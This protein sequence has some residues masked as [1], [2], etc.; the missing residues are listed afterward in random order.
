[1]P[2]AADRKTRKPSPETSPDLSGRWRIDPQASHARFV[3]GT[4]AGLIKTRG[5]FRELSGNLVVGR[6]DAT[7]TLLIDASSI[8]TGNRMR[9]RHLRSRSFFDV[10]RHPQLRYE[11]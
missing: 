11:A 6:T 3:A 4:L 8:D 1:M 5:R 9:D 10:E 7:G 2:T